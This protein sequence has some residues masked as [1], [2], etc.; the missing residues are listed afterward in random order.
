MAFYAFDPQLRR[1]EQFVFWT[2]VKILNLKAKDFIFKI[3]V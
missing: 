2:K 1:E 3:L